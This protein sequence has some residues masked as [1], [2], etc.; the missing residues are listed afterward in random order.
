MWSARVPEGETEAEVEATL[1]QYPT[2][3]AKDP[4]SPG[5]LALAP[6]SK[7]IMNN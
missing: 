2:G 4:D 1:H 7:V 6:S 3:K 5:D